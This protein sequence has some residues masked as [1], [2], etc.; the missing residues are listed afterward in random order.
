MIKVPSC[1]THDSMTLSLL[2]LLLLLLEV[3]ERFELGLSGDS[4]L[5]TFTELQNARQHVVAHLEAR[6]HLHNLRSKS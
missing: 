4:G 1:K 3:A 6:L 5:R 2:Q